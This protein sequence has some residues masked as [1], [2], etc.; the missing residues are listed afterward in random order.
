MMVRI[1]MC[2]CVIFSLQNWPV[3]KGI[4]VVANSSTLNIWQAY[5]IIFCLPHLK[6]SGSL[7]FTH[8]FGSGDILGEVLHKVIKNIIKQI[9]K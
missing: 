5:C 3:E 2:V 1:Q 7:N 8:T 6:L 9:N 4:K